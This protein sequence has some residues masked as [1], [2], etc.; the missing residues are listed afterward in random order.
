MQSFAVPEAFSNVSSK[1]KADPASYTREDLCDG[2]MDNQT[3][4][5]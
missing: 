1:L 5:H 2:W 3:C 4:H